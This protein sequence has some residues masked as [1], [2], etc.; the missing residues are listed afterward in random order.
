MALASLERALLAAD[1]AAD[2]LLTPMVSNSVAWA[3]QRQNRLGDAQQLAVHA[4]DD[5]ERNRLRTAEQVR[6]WGG[7]LISAATSVGRA[8]DY[9]QA[10]DMLT[11]A[12]GAAGR[13]ATLPLPT[14]PK[15][16][17]VFTVPPCGSNEC[18]WR[19]STA[20]P[21]RHSPWHEASG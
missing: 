3:Y 10:S 15:L 6:V 5:V 17:S 8:G 14:N 13:L 12:E 1:S 4:A 19:C 11:V 9:E 20:G 21:N 7:L 2:P 16:V 18:A